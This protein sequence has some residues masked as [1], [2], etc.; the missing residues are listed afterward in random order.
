METC[1]AL[2][3]FCAGNSSVTGEFPSQ[4]LVTP[5]CDVFFDLRLNKRLSK[6]SWVWWFE[7]TSL[8]LWGRCNESLFICNIWYNIAHRS[9]LLCFVHMDNSWSSH[10]FKLPLFVSF[11][12]LALNQSYDC[13]RLTNCRKLIDADKFSWCQTKIKYHWKRDI[14]NSWCVFY[15]KAQPQAEWA[16]SRYSAPSKAITGLKCFKI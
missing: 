8:S 3:A 15:V 9:G 4:R 14:H 2:L 13:P 5:S 7:T 6:Q 12:S 1:S 11:V 16:E 10:R